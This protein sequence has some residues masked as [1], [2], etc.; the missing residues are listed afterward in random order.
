M[1]ES[2]V[3][4]SNVLVGETICPDFVWYFETPLQPFEVDKDKYDIT[5]TKANNSMGFDLS[6]IKS[7]STYLGWC[8]RAIFNSDI[9]EKIETPPLCF[10]NSQIEIGTFLFFFDPPAPYWD[11]VPNFT[12]F[13]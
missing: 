6:A 11:I 3:T 10:Q 2:G 5:A 1:S 4:S 8:L 9:F 13:F 12:V 7:C